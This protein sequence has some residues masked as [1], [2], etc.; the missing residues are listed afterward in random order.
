[1]DRP[2]LSVIIPCH[3]EEA[4][5]KATADQLVRF[6]S[7]E[8]W[9]CGLGKTWEI[10]FV[11]DGSSDATLACLRQLQGSHP[12]IVVATYPRAGGQG[13]A[14]QRGFSEAKGLFLVTIDADLDYKPKYIP[15][16]MRLAVDTNA[17]LVVASPY[18]KG[19]TITNCPKSRLLMSRAINLYFRHVFRSRLST[20][21]A[22]F[23]LYR[24]EAL[25]KLL[26]SSFDKDLLPEI[27]V[28]AELLKMSIIEF[29]VDLSW[30]DE[31]IAL[32]GKGLNLFPTAKKA[33]AHILIGVV[34]NPFY[35]LRYP[36]MAFV[37]AA[38]WVSA[39]FII[40][41]TG[42]FSSSSNGFLQDLTDAL[43]AS[44]YK[45]PHTFV[46]FVGIIQIAFLFLFATLII[47]Q[48]KSKREDDFKVLTKLH[49]TIKGA[50]HGSDSS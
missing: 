49:E 21:T 10:V 2:T 12:N 24:R 44:F 15:Q 8:D 32:R 50:S 29:P 6:F 25:E 1:L 47:I 39:S 31:T 17:D 14:L 38:L 37:F 22:I 23:R 18:M 11:N 4:I 43:T 16:M 5:L 46:F 9:D 20:F 45:S 34:D 7:T 19:G 35:F 36:L 30:S 48:N 42:N 27:I 33:V 41:V 40:L 28:K 13:K 26:L 3:N